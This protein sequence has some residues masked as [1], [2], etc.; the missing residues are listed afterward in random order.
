MPAYGRPCRTRG[1][2]GVAPMGLLER[3]A[4]GG[5]EIWL[6]AQ[7]LTLVRLNGR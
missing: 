3:L 4:I 2:R 5:F 6:L 1:R 7:A